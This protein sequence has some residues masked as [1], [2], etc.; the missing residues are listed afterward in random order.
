MFCNSEL[1]TKLLK[2][3][4]ELDKY[5]LEPLDHEIDEDDDE[6]VKESKRPFLDGDHMTLPDCA[7]LPKL[8]IIQV[9]DSS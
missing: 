9:S 3:L 1:E 5:L 6:E 4:E 2:V 8:N 7:L